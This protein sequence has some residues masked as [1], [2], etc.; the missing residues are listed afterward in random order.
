MKSTQETRGQIKFGCLREG[1]EVGQRELP[2]RRAFPGQLILS[3]R[4]RSGKRQQTQK[5][6]GGD[7]I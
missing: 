6:K 1:F 7:S 5:W 2:F 3:V 4:R